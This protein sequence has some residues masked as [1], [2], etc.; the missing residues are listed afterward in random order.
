MI[1]DRAVADKL[2]LWDSGDVIYVLEDGLIVTLVLV[3]PVNLGFWIEC[4]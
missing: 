2:N 4:L 3:V 1:V